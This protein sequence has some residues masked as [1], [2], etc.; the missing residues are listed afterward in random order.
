ML[1]HSETEMQSFGREYAKNL[2]A[3]AIIELV[4]DVGAG[5]TTFVR[6]LAEGLGVK[7]TLSS[8][9][10]TI[11]RIYA[12]ENCTLTH[13]DFYRLEDPGLMAEDLAESIED[14][15]NV[16]VIEWG[17]SIADFLPDDRTVIEIK[18]IDENTRELTIK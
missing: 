2:S 6:G 5:K 15:C 4:G 9:S 10:F 18:Y 11:S 8:P 1:I 12:G 14:D 7:T 3:P 13:Y 17:Q 16:T